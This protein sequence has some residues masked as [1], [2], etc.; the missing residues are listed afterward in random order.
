MNNLSRLVIV[1]IFS[2]T[3]FSGCAKDIQSA[4]NNIKNQ[5]YT[6]LVGDVANLGS[7]AM[8]NSDAISELLAKGSRVDGSKIDGSKVD[9]SLKTIEANLTS[10]QAA[11]NQGD[12]KAQGLLAF[13]T[14]FK[15][16]NV[17]KATELY[18][19]S[20]NSGVQFSCQRISI[21]LQ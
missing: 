5:N 8:E 6:G 13:Y 2:L 17:S 19:K 11:A 12:P 3:I 20:C 14:E 15:L 7:S 10:I 4:M 9:S 18:K 16:K 1:G 21:N